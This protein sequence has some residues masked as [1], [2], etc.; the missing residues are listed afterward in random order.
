MVPRS[1]SGR[2]DYRGSQ[3]IL[4]QDANSGAVTSA[5]RP[6]SEVVSV[7]GSGWP[8][9]MVGSDQ[10]GPCAVTGRSLGTVGEPDVAVSVGQVLS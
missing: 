5:L 6:S 10:A 9:W 8:G 2:I 3:G 7:E 4:R 1:E